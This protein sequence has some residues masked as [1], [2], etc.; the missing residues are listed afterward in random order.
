MKSFT[1]KTLVWISIHANEGEIDFG[2][3]QNENDA[4]K[5]PGYALQVTLG[6]LRKREIQDI[7]YYYMSRRDFNKWQEKNGAWEKAMRTYLGLYVTG[8]HFLI[9][10]GSNEY[11]ASRDGKKC[12]LSCPQLCTLKGALASEA[13]RVGLHRITRMKCAVLGKLEG[14]VKSGFKAKCLHCRSC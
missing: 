1:D 7:G 4:C 11:P 5:A 8:S 12:S 9:I 2:I 6:S 14:S 13:Y 10:S 3:W